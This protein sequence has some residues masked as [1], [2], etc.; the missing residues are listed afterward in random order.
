MTKTILILGATGGVGG[1]VARA[2][3]R[4]DWHVLALVRDPTQ[5][6]RAWTSEPQPTWLRGDAMNREDVVRAAAGAIVIVHAVN[7]PGYARC[8]TLV[9]PMIDNSIAA[10]RAAGGA[11]IVL[12]GTIYSYDPATTPVIDERTPQRSKGKK[13][14][15]RVAL[16]QR[17]ADAAPDVPSLVVRAGD[18]FGPGVRQSWFAQALAKPPLTRIIRPGKPGVGHAWAYLPDLAEAIAAPIDLGSPTLA[19]IERVQF[20][21]FWDA[22]GRQ[23]VGAIRRATERPD[24]PL[25][26]FPWWLMRLLAPLGGFPREVLE[27]KPFWR[28]PVQLD[29]S[30]LIALLGRATT[31]LDR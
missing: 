29:N 25:R 18:F 22:D 9:Q 11:R 21:G 30:R 19:P 28:H 10:A 13:G 17:L 3:L 4:R 1:A 5:A 23:M 27:V 12:P 26:A 24:L 16:E 2:M 8:E 7:P 15:I 14:R 20:G 31:Y 6:A